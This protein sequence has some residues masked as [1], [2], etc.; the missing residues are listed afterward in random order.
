MGI[1]VAVDNF[2][3]LIFS[4][5]TIYEQFNG[6]LLLLLC[7][8]VTQYSKSLKLIKF[9]V[10]ATITTDIFKVSSLFSPF[11]IFLKERNALLSTNVTM[12]S[13]FFMDVSVDSNGAK[14]L[15][16]NDSE[17]TEFHLNKKNALR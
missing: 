17:I 12:N 7:L 9:T 10:R 6:T 13:S 16:L 2:D 1:L 4:F 11:F 15:D 5:E 8:I 14:H 3:F